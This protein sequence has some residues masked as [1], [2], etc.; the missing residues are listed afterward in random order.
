MNPSALLLKQYR[1]E[2]DISQKKACQLL[3][4]KPSFLSDIERGLKPLPFEPYFA[5][6]VDGY[7]LDAIEI[8]NLRLALL[9]SQR[10]Y[11]LPTSAPAAQFEIFYE[12]YE[13]FDLLSVNQIK[14]IY[15][16]LEL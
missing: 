10:Q 2:K 11:I 4:C 8:Q 6:V 16:V 9:R 14:L 15:G 1:T 12:M 3:G 5:K 13:R 7:Q